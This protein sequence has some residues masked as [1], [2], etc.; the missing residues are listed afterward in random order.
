MRLSLFQP[1]GS[2][3]CVPVTREKFTFLRQTVN[4]TLNFYS[5]IKGAPSRGWLSGKLTEKSELQCQREGF[6]SSV[7]LCST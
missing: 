6:S 3:V 5:Q 1:I 2:L 7:L 4:N